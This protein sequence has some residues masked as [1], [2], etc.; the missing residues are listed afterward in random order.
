[1]VPGTISAESVESAPGGKETSVVLRASTPD[2][3][4]MLY[5]DA[6]HRLIRLEVP[7]SKAVIERE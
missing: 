1:M 5:L 7:S 3:E 6:A 2:L 4:I